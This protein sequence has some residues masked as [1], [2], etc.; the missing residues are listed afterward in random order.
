MT[1]RQCFAL[2]LVDDPD[3]IAEYEAHHAAGRVWPEVTADIRA[4]GII[5]MEIWRTGNRL[6]MIMEVAKDY[7]R[8][9]GSEPRDAAWQQLMWRFQKPL[10]HAAPGEKWVPMSRIYDLREQ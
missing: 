10:P 5:G 2:D 9:S 4:T 3:L 6:F 7:P 1:R 8:S